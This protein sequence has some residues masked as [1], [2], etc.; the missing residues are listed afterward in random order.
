MPSALELI[1]RV[2]LVAGEAAVLYA[3]SR[4]VFD[5]VL[6]PIAG[7]TP[8]RRLLV[9]ILRLPG[10]LLHECSHALGYLV[11]G[12]RVRRIIPAFVDPEGR[13]ACQPGKPWSPIALPWLATGVAALMPLL[14]G[15][16]V[17][18][19]LSA[20]LVPAD[21]QQLAEGPIGNLAAVLAGVDYRTWETWLFVYLALSIG[22]ELAPSEIDLR[23]SLPALLAATACGIALIFAVSSLAPDA[24]LRR[25]FDLHLGWLVSWVSSALDF[26][27]VALV[28]VGVPGALMAW[29]L[30]PRRT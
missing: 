20:W 28:L 3:A 15:A 30:R 25:A 9:G 1:R 6:Q 7:R 11:T 21:P 10:N 22:A 14:V 16:L 27:I 5:R 13:G 18:Q 4:L 26:G 12:Y 8:A 2:L 29:L 23:K 19:G 24:E 17:L